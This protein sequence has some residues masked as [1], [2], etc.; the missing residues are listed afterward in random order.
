MSDQGWDQ[1]QNVF[2]QALD[3]PAE[4]RAAFLEDAC[5]G[6][7]EL[8]AEVESMLSA[9]E[10]GAD[11]AWVDRLA[12]AAGASLPGDEP[13]PETEL[14]ANHRI[15]PYRLI[16][17]IG[18][19]G[20]GRVYLAERADDQYSQQVALKVVRDDYDTGL[21]TERFRAERQILARLQHPNISTLLDGGV[22]AD[23]R[24][25]LVMQ[26]EDGLPITTYCDEHMLGVRERLELFAT[27]CDTVQFAHTNLVV[28]RDLKPNNILVTEDGRPKLLDFGIAKILEGDHDFTRP[29]TRDVRMFTPE[30]A[31]PEQVSGGTITTATDVYAL[32]ILLYELL[33]GQRPFRATDTSPL[34]L[35]RQIQEEAPT[36]PSDEARRAARDG[37]DEAQVT[38]PARLRAMRP[39]ALA[40]TLQG[41]L[42]QIVLEAL[43]KEPERRYGSAREL[44]EDVRRYLA[45][46]PIRARPDSLGYRL[47]K[48]VQRN[49]VGVGVA[50]VVVGLLATL[51]VNRTVQAARLASE[52]ERTQAALV[53]AT[54][55]RD[56]MV[57]LFEGANIESTTERL[58]AVDLLDRGV[59]RA[60]Q[61]TDQPGAQAAMLNAI[62][63]AYVSLAEYEKAEPLLERA[64]ELHREVHG[65]VHRQVALS[66]NALADLIMDARGDY[67][68]VEPLAVEA[69]DI[70]RQ[71]YDG[72]H[73]DIALGLSTVGALQFRRGAFAE[74]RDS[75]AEALEVLRDPAVDDPPAVTTMMANLGLVTTRLGDPVEGERLLREAIA[76]ESELSS[77]TSAKV[78][79]MLNPLAEAILEQGRVDE[80]RG[81]YDDLLE[82]RTEIFG[83]DH[84]AVA[85]VLNNLSVALGRHDRWG[86]A[87]PYAQRAVDIQRRTQDPGHPLLAR[88]LANLGRAQLEAGR[89]DD[90][91]AVLLEALPLHRAIWPE[92]DRRLFNLKSNIAEVYLR[93]DRPDEAAKYQPTSN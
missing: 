22:A 37:R 45:G 59:S 52:Q 76:L 28:H 31:A 16:R 35:Q 67:E 70:H 46:R 93:M 3:L 88:G 11:F 57:N 64:L 44:A 25:Y 40:Q 36:R 85:A 17:L 61:L 38:H 50:V 24:P 9:E 6:D 68:A 77:P 55:V 26:Y 47:G 14:P 80:A 74:A 87:V 78:A 83:P 66:L 8:R 20:M 23:G 51:A 84:P 5:G 18:R 75:Y 69:L 41:D 58:S 29:V 65:D 34:E 33:V 72:P 90:A 73:K 89:L 54:A 13:I 91:E 71:L 7:E 12:A 15:G 10:D 92:D 60:E 30:N 4:D 39:A 43:R 27:I 56:F 2:L 53:E 19:G 62:G 1:L 32:G 49:R 82:L 21:L 42:D 48:F 81:V 86:D 63:R 79:T